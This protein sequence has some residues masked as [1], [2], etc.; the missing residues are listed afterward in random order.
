[1]LAH[2]S[3]QMHEKDKTFLEKLQNNSHDYLIN[4]KGARSD[5]VKR[6]EQ[7]GFLHN[8]FDGEPKRY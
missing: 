5:Y 6:E 4:Y 7:S 1:M 3:L 2:E 8:L